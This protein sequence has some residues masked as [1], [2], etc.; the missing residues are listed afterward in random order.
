M[1]DRGPDLL[2]GEFDLKPELTQTYDLTLAGHERTP[3]E[4]YHLQSE[5]KEGYLRG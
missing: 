2:I 5:D 1:Q 4:R 3:A